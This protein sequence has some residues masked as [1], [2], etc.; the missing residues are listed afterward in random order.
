[1]TIRSAVSG[2]IGTFIGSGWARANHALNLARASR[3]FSDID[4]LKQHDA[5]FCG[6][7]A[8]DE[9]SPI[10][11]LSAGWRS[12]STLLQRMI[13]S[14]SDTI[15]WGEPYANGGLVPSLSAQ[16]LPFSEDWL[17]PDWFR[18]PRSTDLKNDWIAN[19]YPS[20]SDL[21]AAHRSY[22]ERL[23]HAPAIEAGY[24]HW[25]FK[26]VRLTIEDAA[27]LRWLF[28]RCRLLL[29]VRNPY[30]AYLSYKGIGARGYIRWP[31]RPVFT[32]W[33]WGKMWARAASGFRLN[34]DKMDALFLRYEDL[35]SPQ[36]V[37]AIGSYLGREVQS[38]KEMSWVGK[39]P[40]QSLSFIE[41]KLMSAAL[42]DSAEP[43]GY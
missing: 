26:E 23:L 37:Q 30:D 15:I 14:T 41:R 27:H 35:N 12:G 29:L 25:G 1:M 16:F 7:P 17:E 2:F 10:F 19:L 6:P 3:S 28:P 21:R 20:L 9:A 4:Y 31:N 33:Q 24:K 39:S 8:E 40:K 36:T 43:L 13:C 11:I 22:F 42:G 5:A 34:A 32:A 18:S 38:A